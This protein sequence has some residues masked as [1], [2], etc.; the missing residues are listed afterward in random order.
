MLE[1]YKLLSE[2]NEITK[3]DIWQTIINLKPEYL[4]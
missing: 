1:S 3:T 4:E 2:E